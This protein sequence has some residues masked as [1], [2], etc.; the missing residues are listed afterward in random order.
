MILLRRIAS[1][2]VC[3]EDREAVLEYAERIERGAW[4][5]IIATLY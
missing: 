4:A 3:E 5:E 1:E 2:M